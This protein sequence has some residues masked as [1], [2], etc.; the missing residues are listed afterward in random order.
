[1]TNNEDIQPTGQVEA[2]L[3][4]G[5][6]D[7]A[8]LAPEQAKADLQLA[9][10][11]ARQLGALTFVIELAAAIARL[12]L[13]DH[14]VDDALAITEEPITVVAAKG[15][16]IW[17]TDLAP[18]RIEALLDAGRLADAVELVEAFATGLGDLDAPGPQASLTLCRA[19]L[20]EGHGNYCGAATLFDRAAVAWQ[21]L[22]RPY[23]ALLAREQQ[24]RCLLSAEQ[25][26]AG[27]R[28]LTDVFD[29]LSELGAQGDAARVMRTLREH[30]V[31]VRRPARMGR[32]R[33]GNQLSPRELDVVRLLIDGKTNREIAEGL[34]LSPKTVAS[35]VHSAIGK[36]QV[37]SRTTLAIAAMELGVVVDEGRSVAASGDD[38]IQPSYERTP[39]SD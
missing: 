16:W 27:V 22:P 18:A 13:A 21:A 15:I 29:G 7:A 32:P 2:T 34:F 1:L 3:V 33:Y 38:L 10:A 31:N 4:I 25:T 11:K 23:S 20:T 37:S 9:L 8:R 30:G 14:R 19:L 39:S 35:H 12:H 6:L 17:G 36:L 28:V 5:L 26:A 24:A